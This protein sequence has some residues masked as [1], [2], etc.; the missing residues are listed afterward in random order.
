MN[1]YLQP[2]VSELTKLFGGVSMLLNG[3]HFHVKA[4]LHMVV[5]DIPATRKVLALPGHSAKL[6]CSKC[7]KR[8]EA[9][10]FGERLDYSGYDY[11][12]WVKR[13]F[14]EH[15]QRSREYRMLPNPTTQKAFEQEHGL[16]YSEL[17]HLDYF[18][19]IRCHVIDPMHNLFE[20]IAKFFTKNL[21]EKKLINCSLVSDRIKRITSP[22]KVGRLPTKIEANYSGFTA[23]QWRNWCLIYSPIVLVDAIPPQIYT[24]WMF[25]VKAC[26]LLCRRALRKSSVLEADAYLVKFC[27]EATEYFGKP[28]C[29]PNM[30]L[31]LHIKECALDFGPIYGYWCFPFERYNGMLGNYSTNKKDIENQIG[32]K[33]AQE[34]L[35]RSIPVPASYTHLSNFQVKDDFIGDK[36]DILS[37]KEYLYLEEMQCTTRSGNLEWSCPSQ[38]L[39]SELTKLKGKVNSVLRSDEQQSLEKMYTDLYGR[40]KSIAIVGAYAEVAKSVLYAGE[41]LCRGLLVAAFWPMDTNNSE[42]PV[43]RIGELRNILQHQIIVQE[44]GGSSCINHVVVETWWFKRHPQSNFLGPPCVI[45]DTTYDPLMSGHQYIPIQRLHAYCAFTKM[46]LSLPQCPDDDEIILCNPIPFNFTVQ[47]RCMF[48]L[49]HACMQCIRIYIMHELCLFNWL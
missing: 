49:Y 2:I 21:L 4:L 25:F 33:F 23:D 14:T 5:C 3:T 42:S 18:N 36:L 12:S 30:H 20:G 16:R 41:K 45:V 7:L 6:G 26:R 17:V 40:N 35:L 34:Q 1:S 48:I 44:S 46:R 47:Y 8:F 37:V 38:H 27:E 22:M 10:K 19:L 11:A 29:T 13:D 43:L 15:R 31:H 24:I 9:E 32:R 28:I 39:Q